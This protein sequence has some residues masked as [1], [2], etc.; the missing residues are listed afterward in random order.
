M[1]DRFAGRMVLRASGAV[2]L[3]IGAFTG[4]RGATLDASAGAA[5]YVLFGTCLAL[6]FSGLFCLTARRRMSEL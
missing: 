1:I 5:S 6:A 3:G 2:L 4:Y